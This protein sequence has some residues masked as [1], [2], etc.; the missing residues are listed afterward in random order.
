MSAMATNFIQSELS[1]AYVL[2]VVH[3]AGW[4][5]SFPYRDDHG[6]DGTLEAPLTGMSRVDFQ[7]KATTRYD[8]Q[9]SDIAYDLRVE[10][11]NRLLA[12]DDLPRILILF[13]M[14]DDPDEWLS[15]TEEELCLRKCA[16]WASLMGL[17]HSSNVS[18][19]RVHVPLA[20]RF[21]PNGLQSMFNQ[22]RR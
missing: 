3:R 7:L 5:L 2:A 6:I 22:V 8:I 10:D 12:T 4:R 20:N 13:L 17:Q 15:Y 9:G 14:P 18:S 16:Y 21:H 19:Q 11:Y 1:M